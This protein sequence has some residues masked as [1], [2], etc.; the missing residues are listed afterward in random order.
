MKQSKRSSYSILLLLFS[1]LYLTGFSQDKSHFQWKA[2]T[3]RLNITPQQSMWMAGYGSRTK[4]SEGKLTDIWVKA[5]ALEDKAGNRSVLVTMD[6]VG[7]PKK[8][9]EEIRDALKGKLGLSRS[10]IILNTSH[11]HSGPVLSDA[12]FDIY[13]LNDAERDKIAQYT[14]WLTNAVIK[15]VGESFQKMVPVDVYSGNGITRFQVNRRNNSEALLTSITHLNGPN[16]YAV[17]VIK[18]VDKSGKMIAVAFGYACHNTVLSG[19]EWS[20]DY[21]GFAQIDLEKTFPGTM[22]LFFQGCGADLNPLPRRTVAVAK[23]YGQELSSAVQAVLGEDME[24]LSGQIK[25]AYKEIDLPMN[26]PMPRTEMEQMAKKNSGYQSRWASRLLKELDQGKSL[27]WSYPYPVQVWKLG[28]QPMVILGGEVV[29]DY[30]IDLK[31]I[32]GQNLFV[33]G[34]SNDVMSYIPSARILREGGYEGALAP[35]VYGLP[36]TWRADAQSLI[37]ETV[38][39]LAEEAS[40]PIPTKKIE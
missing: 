22:A 7:V 28:E 3:A 39:E 2:G 1:F 13:P 32:F 37:Y 23:Q 18:V 26:A 11:T 16:D 8:V 9:S 33:L 17:P 35:I 25:T 6:L 24:L 15:M 30:A 31:N 12:L 36:A 5:L 38:L 34:Y 14:K 21:A 29:V 40:I 20:G 10:Q 19:Y 27:D 4:P